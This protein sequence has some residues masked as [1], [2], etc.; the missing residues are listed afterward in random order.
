MTKQKTNTI[1]STNKDIVF[2]RIIEQTN[3]RTRQDVDTWRT[4]IAT[5][6]NLSHPQRLQLAQLE[7]DHAHLL[8]RVHQFVFLLQIKF[9]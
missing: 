9:D 7:I 3:W 5:A 1:K 6:E 8:K 4:A 2:S